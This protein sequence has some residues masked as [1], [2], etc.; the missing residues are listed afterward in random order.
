MLNPKLR[1]LLGTEGQI[2]GREF[3]APLFVTGCMRSGTTFLVNKITHHPQLLKIGSELN[4]IW[5]EIGGAPCLGPTCAHK[6][7]EDLNQTYVANM[8]HYFDRFIAESRTLKRHLMRMQHR[9]VKKLETRISYDWDQVIPVNKS[10]HLMNKT[11]YVHAMFPQSKLVLIV[12]G[13]HSQCSSMKIHFDVDYRKKKWVSYIPDDPAGCWSRVPESELENMGEDFSYYPDDFSLLPEMW[14]RL[15]RLALDEIRQL[16][17][18]SYIV[19]SYEDLFTQQ[20][21]VMTRVFEFL[22]LDPQHKRWE[23]K[24][25]GHKTAVINTTTKGNPLEKWKSKLSEK[26]ISILDQFIQDNNAEYKQLLAD[27][28]AV[29]VRV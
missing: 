29:K 4:E 24:I 13:M 5:G 21:E 17:E 18:D 9:Y 22:D 19:I 25:A 27:L 11:G 15:N 10:P 8:V 6:T 20:Y 1:K 26:E 16:P 3:P 28:D 23:K 14:F 7:A 12:R 2:P